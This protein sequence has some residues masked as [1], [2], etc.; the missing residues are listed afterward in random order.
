MRDASSSAFQ[1]S[2][3]TSD[4]RSG[5]PTGSGVQAGLNRAG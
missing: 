2:P 4:A 1:P 3:P 5:N